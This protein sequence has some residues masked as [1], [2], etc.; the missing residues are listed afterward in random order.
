MLMHPEL[1]TGAWVGWNDQRVTFRTN[2]WGQGA[3]NALFLVG[4]YTRKIVDDGRLSKENFPLP[5]DFGNEA[6]EETLPTPSRDNRRVI[7]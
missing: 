5:I 7:W 3:H 1:V 4:D 6:S 2:W